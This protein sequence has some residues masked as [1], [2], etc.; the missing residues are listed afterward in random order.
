VLTKQP[1]GKEVGD[2]DRFVPNDKFVRAVFS[3]RKL[4]YSRDQILNR[5]FGFPAGLRGQLES[6]S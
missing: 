6:V 3:L 4:L 2:D 5:G 1:K